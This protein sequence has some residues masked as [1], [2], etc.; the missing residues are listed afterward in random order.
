MRYFYV[1]SISNWP[2]EKDIIIVGNSFQAIN[3]LELVTSCF[4]LL[5]ESLFLKSNSP[6]TY[7]FGNIN[8]ILSKIRWRNILFVSHRNMCPQQN[9]MGELF[10]PVSLH[11]I[12]YRSN[13]IE[14]SL[15]LVG[16]VVHMHQL[17]NSFP[18]FSFF[19]TSANSNFHCSRRHEETFI[20]S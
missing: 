11:W 2:A 1:H 9:T 5:F 10:K 4:L 12:T 16:N 19:F 17:L 13:I 15:P 20:S 14:S 7:A 3:V 6:E 8:L 18:F